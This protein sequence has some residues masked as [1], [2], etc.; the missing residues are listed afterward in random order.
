MVRRR[1]TLKRLDPWS[2]LKFGFVANVVLLAVVL[3]VAMLV[4]FVV[5][6]LGL[7]EQLCTIALDVGFTRCGVSF[8]AFMRALVLL[9]LLGVVVQT[10]VL[11]FLSF[12][13]NLIADLTGGLSVTVYDR[14]PGAPARGE[15]VRRRA[16]G[17]A[18]TAPAGEPTHGDRSAAGEQRT[19]ASPV[20]PLQRDPGG[21][22]EHRYHDDHAVPDPR[23]P[24]TADTDAAPATDDVDDRG[25][26][27]QMMFGDRTP[28]HDR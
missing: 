23:A 21:V 20:P 16:D 19:A 25:R 4:W 5:A 6:R 13:H 12:L 10:A 7:I 26:D 14:T 3:L 24:D 9:G 27:D 28:R 2:V 11:V 8:G 22:D 18:P 15:A 17:T 1:L